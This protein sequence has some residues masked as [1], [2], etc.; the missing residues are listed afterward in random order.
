M[1]L[2]QEAGALMR[3]GRFGDALQAFVKSS[4]K[5]VGG[6]DVDV[7]YI[8]LLERT[9]NYGHS[10]ALC[11]KVLARPLNK[12]HK[13]IC[14]MTLGIIR[15]DL[16]EQ[17][18]AIG[19]FQRACALAK[20]AA[21]HRQTCWSQLRLMLAVADS[22]GP[23]AVLPLLAEIRANCQR[24]GDPH[25][26]AALHIFFAEMETKRGLL[27]N[28]KRHVSLGRRL[29]GEEPNYWLEARAENVLVAIAIM[30][31]DVLA[32][33]EH[34]NRAL[35]FSEAS[36]AGSLKRASLG[37]LGNVYFLL[38]DFEKSVDYLER[39][40]R[41]LFAGGASSNASL[42]SL[43][44]VRI[45]Q[46]HL[47]AAARC[48]KEIEESVTTPSDWQL[49]PNRYAQLTK[50]E[51]LLQEGA[52]DASLR[53]CEVALNLALRA[54]DHFLRGS[55]L[56]LKSQALLQSN[57]CQ[58]SQSI[59]DEIDRATL[60]LS[61]ELD[62]TYELA[63]SQALA[64][65]GNP[66]EARL[67]C[68]RAQ[69]VFIGLKNA[70]GQLKADRV[71][72]WH[73]ASEK[74]RSL[75]I[76]APTAGHVLQNVAALMSHIGRPEL[77]TTG[78]FALIA[79]SACVDSL[80]ARVRTNRGEVETLASFQRTQIG[81]DFPERVVLI[82]TTHQRTFELVFQPLGT[83]E[84]TATLTAVTRLLDTARDLERAWVEREDHQTIWPL[85]ETATESNDSVVSGKMAE[86]IAF[87]RKI[88]TTNIG[89]LITGESG[90]GKEI[91]ARAIHNF[92]E[93]AGR[94]FVPLNCT[95]VPREMLESQLFGHR[96]GAFTGADRDNLGLV[97]A[98][99]DGS[100]FLDEIGELSLEM[101]PKLLRFLESGEINPL[102]ESSPTVV[103]V[104]VIAA[105]NA[106]LEDSVQDG[107]FREDLYYR[108]NVVRLAIPP[109]RERRDE[110]PGLVHHFVNRAASEFKKGRVRIAEET[111][112][113]LLLY[114]WPGNVRQLQNEIRRMVALADS[115]AVL[116]PSALSVHVLRTIRRPIGKPIPD[117]EMMIGLKDKL[118][119]TL[120][121]IEREM[122]RVALDVHKGRV[123][124]AA[125]ALG[126]S[127]K[128]LYLKRQRLGL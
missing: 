14:E 16:G 82:G 42:E 80:M 41:V 45:H 98:A 19:H 20:L 101:Q 112:E 43:A 88:A 86:L 24:L 28:A 27:Q 68:E 10:R 52:I 109:L 76:H 113:H 120:S 18:L 127:R 2:F 44:Q 26:S 73:D 89:V 7:L 84:A 124:E 31:S 11:E 103:D 96:R 50:A 125:K 5:R 39:A 51:L 108:L 69:R 34:G 91:L 57:R 92:S 23:N 60:R 95:A 48:L 94:P 100:L 22:A 3:A 64:L 83:V 61:P 104:R 107:R 13:S 122:I 128:G 75:E 74:P 81:S 99:K 121:K 38:G 56:L 93:R 40:E 59:L 126:I 37:N 79:E 8:H 117:P 54:G 12:V 102:G 65:S 63:L 119:P 97:R 35:E 67:H 72:R 1:T 71:M 106:N 55:V 4:E 15:N 77:V 47:H 123:D 9:G 85:A 32:G 70:P 33:L 21:D 36:G 111:M 87:A 78:L 90:T 66:S 53:V 49:H 118:T 115:G 30:R 17:H 110:I 116:A 105:T 46:G 58:E 62:A 6:T 29:L 25:V 114:Q